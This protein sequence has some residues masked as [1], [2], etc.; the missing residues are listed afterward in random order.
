MKQKVINLCERALR[1]SSNEERQLILVEA[2]NLF[3]DLFEE[4]LNNKDFQKIASI[5]SSIMDDMLKYVDYPE[6]Y[7]IKI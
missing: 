3:E 1:A 7:S 4:N 5:L 2:S 6:D